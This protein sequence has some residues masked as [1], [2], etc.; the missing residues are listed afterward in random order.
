MEKEIEYEVVQLRIPKGVM[1][2]LRAFVT[3]IDEYLRYCVLDKVR[4]DLESDLPDAG[5]IVDRESILQKY[6]IKE[7]LYNNDC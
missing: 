2:L 4:A 3:D 7:I 1:D 6:G 5:A